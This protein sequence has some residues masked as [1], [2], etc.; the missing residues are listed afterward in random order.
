MVAVGITVCETH[1]NVERY[2]CVVGRR[3]VNVSYTSKPGGVLDYVNSSMRVKYTSEVL[4]QQLSK[5]VMPQPVFFF[6]QG[7][8][9]NTN[10][11]WCPSNALPCAA[12][13]TWV[14]SALKCTR[15]THLT[16]VW[17]KANIAL[18]WPSRTCARSAN[19]LRCA[20]IT[21]QACPSTRPAGTPTK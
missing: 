9:P 18:Q 17:R 8:I 2:V 5:K 20:R 14:L 11:R 1:R 16:H 19:F 3:F 7:P 4:I 6:L 12:D 10:E 15:Y 13:G 21:N